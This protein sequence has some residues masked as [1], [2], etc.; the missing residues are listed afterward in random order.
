[1]LSYFILTG[2][3][4]LGRGEIAIWISDLKKWK[5]NVY[6]DFSGITGEQ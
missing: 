5:Q 6:T 4:M 2:A 3:L 1:M